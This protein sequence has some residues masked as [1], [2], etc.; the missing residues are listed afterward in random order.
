MIDFIELK[1][2]LIKN[3][4][5]MMF[6]H[7]FNKKIEDWKLAVDISEAVG[8]NTY[9]QHNTMYYTMTMT[10]LEIWSEMSNKEAIDMI[11]LNENFIRKQVKNE[12]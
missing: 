3:D 6:P 12:N 11:I 10:S 7:L 5:T 9:K 4:F 2:W 8:I 1:D